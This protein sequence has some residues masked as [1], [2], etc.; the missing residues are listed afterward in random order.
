MFCIV[1]AVHAQV[2]IGTASPNSTLDVRGSMSAGY[3][4][5]SANTSAGTTD[6]TLVFTGTSNTSIS[7]PDA[8]SCSGRQYWIKNA[9][10][11]A[12]APTLTVSTT[13][14]QTID[15]N[16]NWIL[17]ETGE[18]IRIVS[19]GAN[20]YVLN[21]DVAT[22][23]TGT[24]GGA[25][26]EGGNKVPSVKPVGTIS[27][28]DLPFITNN[29]ENM[30]LSTNGYL[31]LG[32]TAPMGRLHTV[33]QNSEL[34]DDIIFD[35]F[36]GSVT[37]GLYMTKSRGTLASPQDLQ[38]GDQ[39]G[40]LRFVPHYNGSLGY[41][42]GS[43]MEVYYK[44]TGTNNLTDL[45]LMTSGNEQ[46]RISENGNVGIG[47]A[48]FDGTNPEK[49][50]V[51][52]GATTSFNVISGKG[53][54]DNYLQLNIQNQSNTGNA[55]SDVVATAAN[56]NE[57]VNY[58]DM[59]INSGAY[60]STSAP[61]LGA[62]N[63]AYLYST[64]KDFVIGNGSGGRN[65]IFFTNSFASSDEKMRITS[66]GNVGI[67][68][69][70]PA[71]K[72][73]VAGVVAPSADNSWSL[74]KSTA[75]WTAVYAANGTIQT[76]DARLKTNIRPLGYGLREVMKL[77]PVRYNWRDPSMPGEKIGLIAQDVRKVVPEVV[78]GDESKE[79]LGMN[80]AEL[81][82]VLI[83]AIKEQ[84]QEIDEIKNRID[85]LSRNK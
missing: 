26:N 10:P 80:Y 40:W 63:T 44:G 39:I 74:G 21:Q 11:S 29:V 79:H 77:N 62:G 72:L 35:D 76:S 13:A 37:Q 27:N 45:R 60:T 83:N 24:A 36:G 71:D 57:S 25:W 82:P 52:A 19:N 15:G 85:H 7:L 84:Q 67:G 42:P 55:S 41:T 8:T 58:V 49:L 28:Y 31:G 46:V 65:L 50:L 66:T 9:S 14:S 30:R 70:S 5:F 16:A 6:N 78:V 69:S 33:S 43:S 38:S 20:W 3:R 12:T 1:L 4:A 23:K 64:G 68:T 47:T 34:G 56:G 81:V 22:A 17:D 54:I 32:T 73:S 61:I 51:Q 18:A 2:G 59:G 75:R 48:S 53:T